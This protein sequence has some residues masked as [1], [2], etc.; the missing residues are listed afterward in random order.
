MIRL[1]LSAKRG[2]FLAEDPEWWM[3]WFLTGGGMFS[4]P[5]RGIGPYVSDVSMGAS[6]TRLSKPQTEAVCEFLKT[7]REMKEARNLDT[8]VLDDPID[9][10]CGQIG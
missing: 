10:W 3:G 4:E 8:S 1:L 9:V 6:L 5:E 2:H 7:I